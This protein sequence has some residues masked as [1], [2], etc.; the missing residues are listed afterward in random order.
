[1]CGTFRK[2]YGISFMQ[3]YLCILYS[4]VQNEPA[5]SL[6]RKTRKIRKKDQK[7]REKDQKA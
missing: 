1:M 3:N 5:G 4:S 2:N 7:I 6:V